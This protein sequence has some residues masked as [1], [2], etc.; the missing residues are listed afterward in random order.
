MLPWIFTCGNS[1][2][3]EIAIDSMKDSFESKK[4]VIS[5]D[6]NRGIIPQAH[7]PIKGETVGKI[8]LVMC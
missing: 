6:Q 3:L 8:I 7:D 2:D 4:V 5:S 1:I